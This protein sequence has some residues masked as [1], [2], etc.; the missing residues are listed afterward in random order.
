MDW[1]TITQNFPEQAFTSF[2]YVVFATNLFLF[3]F[4]RQIVRAFPA[5]HEEGFKTRLFALR[6]TN[7]L[8]FILYFLAVFFSEKARQI[9]Q[10]GLTL[11]V[12]FMIV[13]FS[14]VIIVKK[15]GRTKKIVEDEYLVQTY[16]SEMFGLIVTMVALITVVLTIINIWEL[17]SWLQATS[18]LGVLAL[19]A[20]SS[21]DVWAPDNINGLILLYNGNM[22]A[23]S[24]VRV[25]E[26]NLLAITI[27]TTLTQTTFRDLAT[28]HL[29]VIPNS[30]FRNHKIEVLSNSRNVGLEQWEEF[31]I[32][33]GEDAAQVEAFLHEVW[34][35]SAELEKGIH[36]E[37][38][39]RIRLVSNGDHAVVWRLYYTVSNIYRLLEAKFAVQKSAYILSSTHHIS[40]ATPLTHQVESSEKT[41]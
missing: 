3:V 28:R 20:Y 2:D 4:S 17:T 5:S 12:A 27:Q 23:G 41:I 1:T 18:V 22:E 38:P 26:L 19:I 37:R 33:Y 39:P 36:A 30:I 31:N 14:H 15:F 24:V 35:K 9:S 6:L 32:G 13:H 21:K 7:L 40:L 11:L 34:Q 29:V 25:R 16:Q 10:T 8:L